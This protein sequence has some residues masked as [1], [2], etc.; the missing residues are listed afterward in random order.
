MRKSILLLIVFIGLINNSSANEIINGNDMLLSVN[1]QVTNINTEELLKELDSNP[2]VVLIDVR[3]Q[4]EII[5]LGTILR[6]QNRNIPRGWLEF[7]IEDEAPSK[8]TPIIVYC[9][10]NLRSP[11]AAQTLERMGY[12]NVKNYSDGYFKWKEAGLPVYISDKDPETALYS[13]PVKVSENVYSA[14]GATQPPTY[15]NNNHNN[16]VSFVIGSESVLVFNAGGSY[17]IAKAIH[18][19]IKKITSLPVKYVV[20]ENAQSHAILGSK[21]WKEQGANIIAHELA[22]KEIVSHGN[23]IYQ[24]AAR[25]LKDKIEGSEIVLPDQTYSS[26]MILSLGDT[27]AELLYLGGSHSPDDI[28]LWLPQQKILISGDTTF[29]VRMLPIFLNTDTKS[30]IETFDKIVELNPK[31]IIPGH[32]DPTDLQTVTR[33][34]KDYL[35]Y[36]RS[37]VEKVLEDDGG[38]YEAYLID[39]SR[40]RDWGTYNELHKQNAER[41]FREMEFQ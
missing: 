9:G 11:L 5:N 6:G 36:M 40:Y 26:R 10:L 25:V 17:S 29:N 18:D 15:Q 16:N 24:R 30:W 14:I 21:Y 20:L 2:K 23:D 31:I 35:I 27:V 32:G 12:T 1:K 28:Q 41:I 34:T 37:E 33:F 8:D 7:R 13:K 4:S 3:T 19:E 22:L 39:Q 38:L